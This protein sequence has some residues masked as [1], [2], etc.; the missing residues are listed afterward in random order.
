MHTTETITT[1][2]CS[3]LASLISR[4]TTY[5]LDTI[6]TLVQN[7]RTNHGIVP[8]VKTA[9]STRKFNS[10]FQ[11]LGVT[12]AL[13]VPA[14]TVYFTTYDRVKVT[15]A[16]HGYNPDSFLVHTISAVCAEGF[17][18][19]LFTPMEVM[20]QKLQ[21][22]TKGTT[23]L[24]MAKSIYKDF[25]IRGF[26][27]G[28][29][30]SQISYFVVYE[31]LKTMWGSYTR[32][33]TE[34]ITTSN[35]SG[36]AYFL[37]SSISACIA[38]AITNPPEVIKTR[39]Q[40]AS[41]VNTVKI[42]KELWREGGPRAFAKGM[43]ARMAWI[44]PSMSITVTMF[45]LLKDALLQTVLSKNLARAMC[46]N[47]VFYSTY[48]ELFSDNA[49]QF[50]DRQRLAESF[51]IDIRNIKA[52]P[53]Y[54][55]NQELCDD[56]RALLLQSAGHYNL[57]NPEQARELLDKTYR[58]GK[59]YGIFSIEELNFSQHIQLNRDTP[60]KGSVQELE[61]IER[62][63]IWHYYLKLDTEFAM[64]T[65][66]KFIIE[67]QLPDILLPSYPDIQKRNISPSFDLGRNTMW[68]RCSWSPAF[69]SCKES[70]MLVLKDY[71][72][73]G[74]QAQNDIKTF[75][76][77]RQIIK[78]S[79]R[80]LYEN[81]QSI[82]S[83]IRRDFHNYMLNTLLRFPSDYTLIASLADFAYGTPDTKPYAG[84]MKSRAGYEFYTTCLS[85]FCYIH[86][87]G[88]QL[89]DSTYFAMESNGGEIYSSKDI[90][91]ATLRA[92][93]SLLDSVK[94]HTAAESQFAAAKY[95]SEV[96][97]Q[98]INSNPNPALQS[99]YLANLQVA[100]NIYYISAS[101]LITFQ[102]AYSKESEL[103]RV[104]DLVKMS[105]IPH[106]Q[107]IG[108]VWP[109]SNQYSTELVRLVSS[110]KQNSLFS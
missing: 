50:P 73:P 64:V 79:R 16:E 94:V 86:L 8:I 31:K 101:T 40:I 93:A 99:P 63:C 41:N 87:S 46:F 102:S 70:C 78:F 66:Y 17:S 104:V 103:C 89:N 59:L 67:D 12:L 51:M 19:L 45:E 85:M 56:F 6:K 42:I 44:V 96:L 4:T 107:N 23:T 13:S 18:G 1:L 35:L 77:F 109:T 27:R 76:Y 60:M 106:L 21:V 33:S 43:G 28:Y 48:Y 55:S 108:V 69:D 20:K 47:S 62:I 88:A 71:D 74:F 15:G 83:V 3:S 49:G 7:N 58:L 29:F 25:G 34:S 84:V 24:N 110:I 37:T 98:C 10:F 82:D 26:F 75:S 54:D 9:L 81:P 92:L 22:G 14:S 2:F 72:N 11:G 38:G 39:A 52:L 36:T 80:K 97:Q 61:L 5:P 30:L 53:D 105:V 65:G 57:G 68:Q 32:I 100:F 95:P 90:L 91:F